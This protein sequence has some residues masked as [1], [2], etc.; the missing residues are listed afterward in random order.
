MVK[1]DLCGVALDSMR[2]SAFVVIIPYG[3][4]CASYMLKMGCSMKE[5]QEW[6]GHSDI[7]TSMNVYA[8]LDMDAKQQ[9]ANRFAAQFS[10][11]V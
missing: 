8:H 9:V 10:L 5:I 11:G 3:H 6:L 1:G 4:S 2:L 7:K